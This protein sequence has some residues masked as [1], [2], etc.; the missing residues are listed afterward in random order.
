MHRDLDADRRHVSPIGVILGATGGGSSGGPHRSEKWHY[1][2]ASDL[3]EGALQSTTRVQLKQRNVA[4]AGIGSDV[5]LSP[6]LV[7]HYP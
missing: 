7:R 2:L 3:G 6:R 4:P 5:P 1:Q